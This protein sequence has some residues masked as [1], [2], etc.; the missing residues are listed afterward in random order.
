MVDYDRNI[1][2]NVTLRIRDYG[3]KIEFWIK[4]DRYTYNYRQPWSWAVNGFSG[5]AF[6]R[7]EKGG[8]WQRVVIFGVTADQ[9]VRFSVQNSGLGFPSYDFYQHINRI[10]IPPQPTRVQFSDLT[11]TSVRA[12][13]S[14]QG[15]GGSP[16][17]E[18]QLVYGTNPYIASYEFPN[19]L[20]ASSN[21]NTVITGLLPRTKYY[22]WAR[23]RNAVGWGYL[24]ERTEIVT[25]GLPDPPNPVFFPQVTQNSVLTAFNYFG[26]WDGG[27]PILEWQITYG[28]DPNAGQFTVSGSDINL[29]NLQLAQ[30][31]YFWARGRNAIG[32][33]PWS[34]RSEVLLVAGAYIPVDG[35]IHRAIPWVKIA[36]VWRPAK[37]WT[38]FSGVWR[39]TL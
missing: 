27:S 23:G 36:G 9:T 11:S 19:H 29:T 21:G 8:A 28:L 3:Q 30:R 14:G 13:F 39:P 24:S 25:T 20:F 2:G 17:L 6:Y 32:W 16:V 10:T 38:K 34:A 37:P 33:S 31:Y 5:S 26:R 12:M 7:L 18:W 4:A 1:G 35:V 22:F 15:D